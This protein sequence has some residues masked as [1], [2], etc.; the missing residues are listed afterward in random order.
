M[1]QLTVHPLTY[2]PST[3]YRLFR[4][5]WWPDPTRPALLEYT[6]SVTP[7]IISN[8]LPTVSSPYFLLSSLSPTITP[9]LFLE[10]YRTLPNP[11]NPKNLIPRLLLL[12]FCVFSARCLKAGTQVGVAKSP[13][14]SLHYIIHVFHLYLLNEFSFICLWIQVNVFW[15]WLRD[16]IKC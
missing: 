12:L 1:V 15:S 14:H 10:N 3:G 11:K 5:N 2:E 9:T 16:I 6:Y 13:T 7:T 4:K 8:S